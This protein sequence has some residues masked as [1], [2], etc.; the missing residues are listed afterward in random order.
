[1]NEHELPGR[2]C[3]R[4]DQGRSTS[5][6]RRAREGQGRP[7]LDPASP[8]G[9]RRHLPRGA[10]RPAA[11]GGGRLRIPRASARR[12]ASPSPPLTDEQPVFWRNKTIPNRRVMLPRQRRRRAGA[13]GPRAHGHR[14]AAAPRRPAAL[15]RAGERG[16]AWAT[17]RSATGAAPSTA[18]S[19]PTPTPRFAGYVVMTRRAIERDGPA[20]RRRARRRPPRAARPARPAAPRRH[21]EAKRAQVVQWKNAYQQVFLQAGPLPRQEEPVR[22]SRST[23]RS[24]RPTSRRCAGTSRPSTTPRS[25]PHPRARGV[26]RRG[27]RG[28]RA[29]LGDLRHQPALRGAPR[30]R[31][32]KAPRRGDATSSRGSPRRNPL[33]EGERD[34]LGELSSGTLGEPTEE[35]ESFYERHRHE[36]RLRPP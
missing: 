24:W 15:G 36:P 27:P 35:D 8:T 29:R 10:R 2:R 18:C 16:S 4:E 26:D 7:S 14:R 33:T 32:L 20:A 23:P 1:M 11:R 17:R 22:S 5:R 34:Y 28:G 6:P 30:Q 12:R 31:S 25:R 9:G 19:R 13:V 21:P 3:R